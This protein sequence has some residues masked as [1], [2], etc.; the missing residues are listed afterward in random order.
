MHGDIWLR[1]NITN[2]GDAE[3]EINGV[4]SCISAEALPC[5]PLGPARL[6]APV[7]LK[8]RAREVCIFAVSFPNKDE[9]NSQMLKNLEAL[10]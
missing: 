2:E 7:F 10:A 9:L 1:Q 6:W 4:P 8:A 3:H 5:C